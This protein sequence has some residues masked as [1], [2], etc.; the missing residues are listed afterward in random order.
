MKKYIAEGL[1]SVTSVKDKALTEASQAISLIKE[2][3]NGIPF[4]SSAE[5]SD[6]YGEE[7]FD[8]RHYF[9]VPFKLNEHAIAI[10]TMRCLP[11]NVPEINDLPKRRIFH[12][13][14]EYS[15]ALVKKVLADNAKSLIEESHDRG[16]SSLIHLANEIDAMDKKLTYGMIFVGGVAALVNPLIGAGIALKAVTPSISKMLGKYGFRA[17]GEKL[18][19][20]DLEK[21][22]QEAEE[23]VLKEFQAAST[24]QVV[25][26]I[27]QE[28]ELALN[29]TAAEHDPLLDFDMS[30][31]SIGELDNER[32]RGLTATALYHLYSDVINDPG[33]HA[34]ACLGPEDVRWLEVVFSGREV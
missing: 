10:P 33:Q 17:W 31:G 34:A 3:V 13:A 30:M 14:N 7:K 29:T 32:W 8:E 11:D 28:L 27:L 6:R 21:K 2:K 23:G 15:E 24:L 26:P 5:T 1:K 16:D 25:N 18:N 4:F 22:I 12:F 19:K 9:I 20:H